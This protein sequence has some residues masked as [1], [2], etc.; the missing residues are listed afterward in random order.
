MATWH[1]L[2]R[3]AEHP[4]GIARYLVR[5]NTLYIFCDGTRNGQEWRWNVMTRRLKFSRT[6][7]NKVDFEQAGEVWYELLRELD[8]Y[9]FDAVVCAGYSRG[10]AIAQILAWFM[11]TMAHARAFAFAGKRAGNRRFNEQMPQINDAQ[12]GDIVPLLPPWYA[13]P[14]MTWWRPW[15][16]PWSAHIAMGREAARWRHDITR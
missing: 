2:G 1:R 12:F 7:V 3:D 5:G 15:M 10:G 11:S 13:R 14:N 6:K 8:P 4:A 16:M 9:S